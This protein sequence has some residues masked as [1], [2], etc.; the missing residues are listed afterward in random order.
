MKPKYS[1][2]KNSSYALSGIKFLLKDEKS[3]RLEVAITLPLIIFSLFLPLS[4][5]EHFILISVLVLIFI[6]EALNSAIE[7]CVDLYTDDF[8]I[9]AKKAKD[10]GSAAVFFSVCLAVCTWLVVLFKVFFL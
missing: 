8:H 6:V 3:F 2:F 10:C 1:L 5:A 4:F 9:L 7:A